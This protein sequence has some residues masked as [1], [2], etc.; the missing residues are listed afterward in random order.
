MYQPKEWVRRISAGDLDNALCYLYGRES[1]DAQ[2]TRYIEALEQF[3]SLFGERE[4]RLFSAPGR[5]E[6]GGN[7]TDHQR[8]RV[9]AGSVN[10]DAI[11]VAAPCAGTIRVQSKGYPRDEV[12]L[13][14]L[15]PRPDEKNRSAAVIRGMAAR[16]NELG[17]KIGGFDAY[18]TSDVLGGSGLSSSAAFEMLIGAALNGLYNDGAL[19]PIEIAQIGQYAENVYFGKPSGLLDQMASAVGGFVT[20]DFKDPLHP[21]IKKVAYDFAASGCRLCVVDT[22]G[23]HAGLT[24]EY[25]AIP[26][27]MREVAAFFGKEV[28]REVDPDEFFARIGEVYA[29]TS[30]RAVARAIHF[31]GDDARVARQVRALEENRFDRFCELVVESGRSSAMYLQ[32]VFAASDPAHQGLTVAL[33]LSERMLAGRGAWRVHGGG[34]AGTIQAYVPAD[35]LEDYRRMIDGVYG[36]GSCHV[37]SIRPIGEC[38]VTSAL[39]QSGVC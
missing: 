20:A 33:A 32:N 29:V 35:L 22:K 16:F 19:S 9:L 34:F 25:G 12:E 11:A 31:F 3:S 14:D 5:T 6:A 7:H 17:H 15:A 38:E 21:V 27:E 39:G 8:G 23:D 1:L 26:Q 10:L 4:A 24:P 2:R 37:L 30:N 36:P 28:L 13:K 18:T